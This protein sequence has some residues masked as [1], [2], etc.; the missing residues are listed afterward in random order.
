MSKIL[1]G[2]TSDI[3]PGQL[4]KISSEGKD[5]LLAN[6]DGQYYAMDDTCTHMGASLSEGKLEGSTVVC[7]WHGAQFD[8]KTGKLEKF[9]AKVNDLKSYP[10]SIESDNVFVEV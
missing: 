9:P 3:V 7:G 5:I 8:C 2:K 1:A 10:V 6:I 4:K